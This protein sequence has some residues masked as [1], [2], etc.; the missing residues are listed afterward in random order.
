MSK[1]LTVFLIV[2]LV[3]AMGYFFWSEYKEKNEVKPVQKDIERVEFESID[4]F[5]NKTTDGITILSFKAKELL[6]SLMEELEKPVE[7]YSFRYL[8]REQYPYTLKTKKTFGLYQTDIDSNYYLKQIWNDLDGNLEEYLEVIFY[9]EKLY[10]KEIES[11]FYKEVDYL[12]ETGLQPWKVISV[13]NHYIPKEKNL[14]FSLEEEMY[15]NDNGD[16]VFLDEIDPS[17]VASYGSKVVHIYKG[18]W[19]DGIQNIDLYIYTQP[20]TNQVLAGRM[21]IS[22]IEMDNRFMIQFMLKTIS[23]DFK[24]EY[25]EKIMN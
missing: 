25:P 23:D 17:L 22:G 20:N 4:L 16:I 3:L 24:I 18:K 13:M 5:P 14:E 21:F 15:L 19:E 2:I 10:C 9:E 8:K 11:S 7:P 6:N 12:P 1:R